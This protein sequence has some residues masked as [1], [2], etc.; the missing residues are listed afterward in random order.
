MN[1]ALTDKDL[2]KIFNSKVNIVSYEDLPNK[3]RIE[4]IIYPYNNTVIFYALESPNSGHWLA[5]K[6]HYDKIIFFDSFGR[7]DKQILQDVDEDVKYL[8]NEDYPY[9][10]ELLRKSNKKVVINK[11][12]LQ[13]KDSS[14]C[15]RWCA[16]FLY[17]IP[18]F[19]TLDKLLDS[20]NF[21]KDTIHNDKEIIKLTKYYL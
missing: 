11:R 1:K 10:T 20:E 13:N 15:G 16:W 19:D 17:N 4:D 8:T 6:E 2:E 9:L 3:K 5:I 7:T 12:E 18:M 21:K 14:T